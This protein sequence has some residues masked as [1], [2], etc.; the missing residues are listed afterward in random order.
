MRYAF[1]LG[2]AWVFITTSMLTGQTNQFNDVVQAALSQHPSVIAAQYEVTQKERLID[3]SQ[4]APNPELELSLGQKQNSGAGGLLYDL[5]L[6]Q[7]FVSDQKLQNYRQWALQHRDWAKLKLEQTKQEIRYQIIFNGYAYM[8]QKDYAK[9]IQ[10]RIDRLQF[11]QTYLQNRPLLSPQLQVNAQLF[12]NT[13]LALRHS[14]MTAENDLVGLS[15]KLEALGIA[16]Q[17]LDQSSFAAQPEQKLLKK[18]FTLAQLVSK[19]FVLQ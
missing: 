8:W 7:V 12:N 4:I 6:S 13:L 15:A 14:V 16:F 19:D 1:P 2:V 3:Q 5:S 11:V 17:D 9:T 18:H 10:R